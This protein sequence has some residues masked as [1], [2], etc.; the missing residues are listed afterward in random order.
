MKKQTWIILGALILASLTGCGQKGTPAEIQWEAARKADDTA[1][2]VTEHKDELEELKAEAEAG[3]SLGQQFK[4]TALLCMAE[5]QENLSAS[6]SPLLTGWVNHDVFQFD[7]PNTAGYADNYFAKIKTDEAAFWESLEDAYYPYDYF[8]PMLAAT[9]N[10]DGEILSKLLNGTGLDSVCKTELDEAIT[11]WV[12]NNPGKAPAVGDQLMELGYFDD[13]KDYDWTGTYLSKSTEPYLVRTNTADEALAYIIYMQD[14]FLP[15]MEGKVSI[16]NYRKTSE[17]TGEEYY[18]T[19][20]AVTIREDLSLAEPAGENLPE[21]IETEG[22][23]VVALYHNPTAGEDV[24][25]PPSWRI[26]GDFLMG[27]PKEERPAAMAEADYYLVL[28]SDHQPGSYY[29][30][31]SGN[32]TKIRAV[33]SSSSLD[34]YDAATGAF[35]RHIGNIME[36]PSNTIFKNLS[37]EASQYPELAGADVLSYIYHHINDPDSYR[38]LLDHTSGLE[39]PLTPGSTGLL[40]PWEITT[41]SIEVVKSFE[42]GLF[43]YTAN[44]GCQFVR[45]HLTVTNQGFQSDNFLSGSFHLNSADGLYAGVIDESGENVY[46]AASTV[47]G[48]SNLNGKT[49]EPGETKE[50]TILFEVEENALNGNAP[51]YLTF[52]LGNQVLPY[53]LEQ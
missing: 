15:G 44:D 34:L 29:Q 41:T 53:S 52:Y 12:Q 14:T 36:N 4:A 31:T 33:Y 1:A 6:D 10:M 37:E 5:Y 48:G 43:V 27:L 50:G 40:G 19:N 8:L 47:T 22:K 46:P 2:Y 11:A 45:A 21:T 38:T 18:S 30:D 24:D 28:T 35:L 49:L 25:A 39:A 17:T 16:D 51:L 20:I 13:W 9:E 42:D 23:K 32:D 26:L 7:Y 3:E